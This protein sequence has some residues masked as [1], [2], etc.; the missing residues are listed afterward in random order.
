MAWFFQLL[1]G[2]SQGKSF[3][4]AGKKYLKIRSK[5][6]NFG[7]DLLKTNEKIAPQRRE[8]YRHLHGGSSGGEGRGE[9]VVQVC[10]HHHTPFI[11]PL[12]RK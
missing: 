9:G 8:I 2:L 5:V 10:T 12:C 1:T 3:N 6:V 7:S 4:T 11:W